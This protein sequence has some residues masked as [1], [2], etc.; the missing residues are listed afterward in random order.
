MATITITVGPDC[1]FCATAGALLEDIG[2]DVE[3]CAWHMAE[4]TKAIERV[5][6]QADVTLIGPE[7]QDA[8]PERRP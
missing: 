1:R 5:D 2:R 7:L 6:P 3:L 8:E 4:Y